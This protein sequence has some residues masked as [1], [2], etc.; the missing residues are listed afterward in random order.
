[1]PSIESIDG[2]SGG[3][4]ICSTL[5]QCWLTTMNFVNFFYQFYSFKGPRVDPAIGKILLA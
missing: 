4:S 3:E 2:S 5:W 1:M